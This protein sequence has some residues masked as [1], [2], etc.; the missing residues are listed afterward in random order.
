M[1]SHQRCTET[2]VLSLNSK[3]SNWF[4]FFLTMCHFKFKVIADKW[5]GGRDSSYGGKTHS[6]LGREQHNYLNSFGHAWTS[7][8]R[9]S[10]LL[11]TGER[12]LNQTSRCLSMP[13]HYHLSSILALDFPTSWHKSCLHVQSWQHPQHS[14]HILYSGLEDDLEVSLLT[15]VLITQRVLLK[16]NFNWQ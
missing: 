11:K 10:S 12:D 15:A 7:H 5:G 1:G 9:I 16:K 3:N 8:Q 14:Y 13:T 2:L 4:F 6:D